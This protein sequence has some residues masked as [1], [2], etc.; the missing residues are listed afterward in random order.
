[1]FTGIIEAVGT[2]GA[3]QPFGEDIRLRI[4]VGTLDMSDVKLGDSI[5]ANGVCLTVVEFSDQH[6]SVDVSPETLKRSG[7]ADYQVG[8]PVNLEK[9]MLASSRFGGHIV[10]GHVD[11]VGEVLSLHPGDK[12]LEIWVKAPD[13]LARYLAE[14]G[15]ITVDGVSLTVN[16]IDGARFMLTLI[17]HTL[18]ETIIGT[19]KV[20]TKVNL[21]VDVVARYLERLMLGDKAAQPSAGQGIDEAFLAKHGYMK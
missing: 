6:Y 11:G 9:A 4:D 10:S 18:Q 20:G 7:F 16:R 13:N 12:W 8:M 1:M 21:E 2:I 14:K 19:Y 3:M 17:P 15:S 5:A